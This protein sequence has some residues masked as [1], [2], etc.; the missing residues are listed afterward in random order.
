MLKVQSSKLE[1]SVKGSISSRRGES[2]GLSSEL[3]SLIASSLLLGVRMAP[4][5]VRRGERGGWTCASSTLDSRKLN[6]QVH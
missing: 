6:L 4:L 5:L 3:P 2:E 1:P